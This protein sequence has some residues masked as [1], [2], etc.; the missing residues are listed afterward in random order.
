MKRLN[1]ALC[2]LTAVLLLA[3]P[4]CSAIIDAI[5]DELPISQL[6][7]SEAGEETDFS[8]ILITS[9]ETA[10]ATAP[11]SGE[12]TQTDESAPTPTPTPT[13]TTPAPETPT[14]TPTPTPETPTPTPTPENKIPYKNVPEF[15]EYTMPEEQFVSDIEREAAEIIDPAICRA[16]ATVLVMKDD[17]HSMKTYAYEEDANGY[18]KGLT[19]RE[20]ELYKKLT[21]SA[22]KL[23]EFSIKA[24]NWQGDLITDVLTVSRPISLCRP[25]LSSYF[26]VSPAGMFDS[27]ES[28][29]FDPYRDSNYSVKNGETTIEEV[30]RGAAL[31]QAI[32]KRIVKK[33]PEGLTTYD[34]YF[35]LASVLC[36]HCTYDTEPDNKFKPFG[37][38]VTG[39]C[40][41]EGYSSAYLLLCKEADLWCAYRAGVP[42]GEGHIWNM[43][44]L[45]SGIYN[46]DVT[47]CDARDTHSKSWYA[48]FMKSDADFVKDG[49]A[50]NDG[51]KGTGVFEPN[52]YQAEV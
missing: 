12:E 3:T 35:Y 14:P 46:V 7:P 43:V 4:S 47:W 52:P 17:R 5:K 15:P 18:K 38:L 13:P 28:K 50:A 10:D 37:A 31:M 44:K 11:V 26:T 20:E 27:V 39:R 23:E 30:R 22:E 8:L 45:D 9:E 32:I 2:V 41:C 6:Q 33:M 42:N 16:I 34:K 49:H 36:E 51:V 24:E 48:Y 29:Y 40:V 25:D 21:E 1:A 19:K